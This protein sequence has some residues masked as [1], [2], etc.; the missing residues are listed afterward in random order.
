M[1]TRCASYW[2]DRKSSR[3]S[4][5]KIALLPSRTEL[6]DLARHPGA[7]ASVAEQNPTKTLMYPDFDIHYDGLP[8][9][10]PKAQVK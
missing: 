7:T 3:Q 9:E 4:F 10:K 1:T 6:F 8:H 5:L 2:I